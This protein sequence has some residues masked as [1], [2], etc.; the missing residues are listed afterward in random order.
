MFLLGAEKYVCVGNCESVERNL[1]MYVQDYVFVVCEAC[2]LIIDGCWK[3][4]CLH[5]IRVTCRFVFRLYKELIGL[6]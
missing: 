2:L 1:K 5:I 3:S 4:V 6:L